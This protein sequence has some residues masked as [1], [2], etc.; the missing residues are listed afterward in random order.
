ML[1]LT[2]LTGFNARR[3]S[4]HKRGSGTAGILLDAA[5]VGVRHLVGAGAAPFT[6]GAA[7]IG[8]SAGIHAGIG[9][10][11]ITLDASGI[12]ARHQV[13][14]GSAA[15]TIAADG[16]GTVFDQPAGLLSLWSFDAFV[17]GEFADR[18]GGPP[19][20]SAVTTFVI[21][22]CSGLQGAGGECVME[23]FLH[24]PG[25]PGGY[26]LIANRWNIGGYEDLTEGTILCWAKSAG[27]SAGKHVIFSL[28][29][30]PLPYPTSGQ[31]LLGV[32]IGNVGGALSNNVWHLL[33]IRWNSEASPDG[34]YETSID[35]AAWPDID[36]ENNLPGQVFGVIEM[37]FHRGM[38]NTNEG[39]IQVDEAS[40]WNRMLSSSELAWLYNSGAGRS[41]PYTF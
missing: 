1:Q 34:R 15:I 26:H 11:S 9:T 13:G 21:Q 4:L 3:G 36:T 35:G 7:G 33:A 12:G 16:A 30:R 19:L 31:Q 22:G 25:P 37:S 27:L 2:Q 20:V 28:N 39:S 18:F 38:G 29:L 41:L 40:V 14:G 6:I 10:A 23:N 24:D 32:G 8:S 17:G 5:G